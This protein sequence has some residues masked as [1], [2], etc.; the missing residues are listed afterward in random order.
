[1]KK[2]KNKHKI[3]KMH[4]KNILIIA[5]S[6]VILLGI[7]LWWYLQSQTEPNMITHTDA[8]NQFSISD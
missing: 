8:K 4:K 3:E 1:M 6:I 5:I 2:K 7:A